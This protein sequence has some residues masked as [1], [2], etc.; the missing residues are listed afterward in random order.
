MF[1][2]VYDIQN[3]RLRT[4]FSKFLI[5]FGRRIQYSVFEITNSPRIL[6]NI[7]SE[8]VTRFEKRFRQADSVLIYEIPDHAC[9]GRFGYPLNEE[10][11]LL[12]M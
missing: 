12:L 3:D 4:H 2:V 6:D 1:I 10:T 8:I 9:V 5:K 7:K 11:D